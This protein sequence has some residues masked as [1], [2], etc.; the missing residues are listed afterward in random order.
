M[1]VSS[2]LAHAAKPAKVSTLLSIES[3][4]L[5]LQQLQERVEVTKKR[6]QALSKI[7]LQFH[8]QRTKTDEWLFQISA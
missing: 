2:S 6:A 3:M 7:C 8:L 4:E 5:S 1:Q